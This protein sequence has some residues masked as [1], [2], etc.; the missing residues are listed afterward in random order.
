MSNRELFDFITSL[1][2]DDDNGIDLEIEKLLSI[3]SSFL[4]F[5]TFSFKDNFLSLFTFS[6]FANN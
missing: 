3:L 1:Y 4:H 2:I 5:L 6:Y